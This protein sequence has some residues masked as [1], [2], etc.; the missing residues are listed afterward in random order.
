MGCEAHKK[1]R[2]KQM[3]QILV[4]DSQTKEVTGQYASLSVANAVVNDLEGK[5]LNRNKKY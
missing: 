5:M 3:L 1:E 4:I 2:S